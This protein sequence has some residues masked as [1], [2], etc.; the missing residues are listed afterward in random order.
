MVVSY[1]IGQ[2]LGLPNLFFSALSSAAYALLAFVWV[3]TEQPRASLLRRGRSLMTVLAYGLLQLLV[4]F[5]LSA[6]MYTA[7]YSALVPAAEAVHALHFGLCTTPLVRPQQQPAAL[8]SSASLS[9]SAPPARV[10]R[11]TFD[12]RALP[13]ALLGA[14][15]AAA[16]SVGDGGASDGGGSNAAAASVAAGSLVPPLARAYEYSVELCIRLPESPANIEAGT[17]LASLR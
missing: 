1:L 13:S 12:E 17:F 14:P 7:L 16:G 6:V 8:S 11:L 10:A 3:A 9:S 2:I 15:S 5:V 4:S